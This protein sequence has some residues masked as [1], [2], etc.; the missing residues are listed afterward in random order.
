MAFFF[1]FKKGNYLFIDIECFKV[2]N[3][4]FSTYLKSQQFKIIE[5]L[6]VNAFTTG[7]SIMFIRSLKRILNI[8]R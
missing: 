4:F 3:F 8:F 5:Y 7:T 6:I 2:L 1:L